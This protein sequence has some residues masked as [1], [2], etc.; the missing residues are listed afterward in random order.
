MTFILS[1]KL[2]FCYD[3]GTSDYLE[4]TMTISLCSYLDGFEVRVERVDGL[5]VVYDVSGFLPVEIGSYAGVDLY[6]DLAYMDC[7]DWFSA[8]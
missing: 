3:E 6:M 7:C 4:V 8:E 2:Y 5:I 1:F